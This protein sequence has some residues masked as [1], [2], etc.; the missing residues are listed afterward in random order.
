[1]PTAEGDQASRHLCLRQ[2]RLQ[3]C[4]GRDTCRCPLARPL[5]LLHAKTTQNCSP[6]QLTAIQRHTLCS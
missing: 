6:P 4:I 3:A 2:L 5:R 1:M